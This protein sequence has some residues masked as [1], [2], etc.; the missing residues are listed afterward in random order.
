MMQTQ[1]GMRRTLFLAG[2]ATL[3]AGGAAS[4]QNLPEARTLADR[5]VQASGGRAAMQRHA[6]RHVV[7]EMSMPAMGMTM[8]VETF[9]ARPNKLLSKVEMPG[10]GSM[11]V[12]YDGT[13]AWSMNPMQGPRIL[14]GPEMNQMLQQADFD[15]NLDMARSFPTMETVG[16]RQVN[17][18]ACW[19]VRMVHASGMQM[20]NCFD[21][22]NGL[23]IGALVRQQSAM[24]DVEA[25]VRFE[26]YKEFDGVR[27]PTRV[28]TS[29]MGQEMVVTIKSVD[30]NPID[31]ATFA[32]P[33]EIRALR[34]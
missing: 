23:L 21:K 12:G 31:A 32:L 19:N 27:M 15:A 34:Q 16:E 10:M 24:G 18:R 9:Q 2:A 3:L 28:V 5:Y 6:Q 33:A 13:V 4:A 29:A 26:E 22:E 17:G 25:E 20:H 14:D 11:T 8:S 30:H 1:R 7:S